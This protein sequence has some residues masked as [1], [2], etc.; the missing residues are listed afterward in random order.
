MTDEQI[1]DLKQFIAVT[2]GQT[3]SRLEGR[4]DHLEGRMDGIEGR[5]DSL[6]EKLEAVSQ[7]MHD[8]FAGIAEII[9]YLNKHLDER[10]T[11]LQ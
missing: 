7:E 4:I 6:D 5:M 2:V 9:D 3:E 8:G 11:R 1:D 10:L